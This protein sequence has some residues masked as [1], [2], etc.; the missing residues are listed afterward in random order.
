MRRAVVAAVPAAA[1]ALSTLL[2][3]AAP[4]TAATT[5]P[6]RSAATG[7]NLSFERL[8][9]ATP[10]GWTVLG[11]TATIEQAARPL[12]GKIAA[13]VR[14][15]AAKGG[16]LDMVTEQPATGTGGLKVAVGQVYDVGI[17]YRS[18][19]G[20]SIVVYVRD[21]AGWRRWFV[22]APFAGSS[23]FVKAEMVT[24]LLPAGITAVSLGVAFAGDSWV[25]LDDAT[26]IVAET[27]STGGAVLFR[28]TF[29]AGTGLVTN[30]YAFWNTKKSDVVRSDVWEVTSG[31]LFSRAGNG[32]TGL[33]TDG[34][35]DARSTKITNSATF[36]AR[37]KGAV[38]GD[39][40]LSA[41]FDVEEL[42]STKTT[43]AQDYDG[44]HLWLRYQS[45]V[46]LYAVSV[47]RRDG[48]IVI[49]K[50]CPGGTSN[51]G[52]YYALHRQIGGFA[53]KA[54]AWRDS[55]T[56]VRTNP[57]GSVTITVSLGGKAVVS[58]TDT[59]IGCAPITA[60]GTVGIRGDNTRFQFR[61][62][63]VTSL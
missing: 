53:V 14:G 1:L 23:T 7:P 42:G 26:L 2:S 20:V 12:R 45:E 62:L 16:T 49:K 8:A 29:P 54:G 17:W 25:E 3:G 9:G 21:R 40:A 41:G 27:A 38:Y 31:S 13:K 58:A 61:N 51:D 63:N 55:T 35:P 43:P 34:R 15:R 11:G 5:T 57:S 4:A 50:K 56:S 60:P 28:P 33:I 6:S 46:S 32:W 18:P 48:G 47:V 39:V 37:T 52:T 19:A 24:P 30:E 36:R 10:T 59:G 22:S 44:V